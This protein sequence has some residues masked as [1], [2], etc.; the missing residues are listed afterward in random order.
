MATGAVVDQ[1]KL[2][3]DSSQKWLD[4]S[5]GLGTT[6]KLVF[7]IIHFFGLPSPPPFSLEF[8]TLVPGHAH[9]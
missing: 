3:F 7:K 2:F 8:W 1:T 5:R 9:I 4:F 6:R